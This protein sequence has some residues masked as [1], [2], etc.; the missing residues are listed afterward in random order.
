MM[1]LTLGYLTGR[2]NRYMTNQIQVQVSIIIKHKSYL[3][4]NEY[5]LRS[6]ILNFENFFI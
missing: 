3:Y 1:I 6:K 4:E 2:T 5:N